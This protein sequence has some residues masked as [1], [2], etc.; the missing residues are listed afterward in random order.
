MR[1]LVAILLLLLSPTGVAFGEWLDRALP[2]RRGIELPGEVRGETVVVAQVATAGRHLPDAAD[3]RIADA[4][5]RQTPLRVL[6]VGPG[7]VVAVAFLARPGSK[8]YYAYFGG[9]AKAL[10]RPPE[11]LPSRGGLLWESRVL[12]DGDPN[13]PQQFGELWNRSEKRPLGSAFV[14]RLYVGVNP[15]VDN[16]RVIS[17]ITGTI[18]V[19]ADGTYTFAASADDRA[20]LFIDDKPVVVARGLVGDARFNGEVSL[21]RGRHELKL[22]HYDVGGDCRLSVLWRTPG[23][24]KYEPIPPEA[25]GPAP[26]TARTL[27]LEELRAELVADFESEYLDECFVANALTHRVRFLGRATAA[28]RATVQYE[29]DFGDGQ[30]ARGPQVE[31]VYLAPGEYAVKVTARSAALKDE[32]ITRLSVGRVYGAD[33]KVREAPVD[34][35]AGVVAGYDFSRLEESHLPVASLLLTRA[36][37]TDALLKVTERLLSLRNHANPDRSAEALREATTLLVAE[38]RVEQLK[39]AFESIPDRSNLAG[40]VGSLVAEVLV[41]R[42][43]DYPTAVRLLQ[44][45]SVG[46]NRDLRLAL[47]EALLLNQQ[48]EESRKIIDGVAE[49]DPPAK[50]VAISGAMA[51]NVEFFVG[52]DDREAGEAEWHR[53][54]RRFPHDL[55]DGYSVLLRVRLVEKDY[56]L[57]AARAAEAFASAVPDSPYAPQL[58]DRAA[59]LLTKT[60]SER[61][62]ELVKKL[63]ERYPESP[64]ANR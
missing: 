29:W 1:R 62:A 46:D 10:P 16:A 4:S 3:L 33:A 64:E 47:A 39:R 49:R 23:G 8:R 53:W 38:K 24:S 31:H 42:D 35:H 27:P 22:Y 15:V 63:K 2:L 60:D 20:V 54:M 43:G 7:D 61:A 41:W 40:V 17:R 28:S 19:P 48:V 36:R 14:D 32:R 12:A 45:L 21:K 26:L 44:R 55:L 51:R 5:G 59:S 30:T 25:F 34:G 58:L 13:N 6:R 56:P 52:Q 18:D 11:P 37:K 57:A 9:D 50:R